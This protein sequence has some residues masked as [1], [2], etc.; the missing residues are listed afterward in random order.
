[1]TVRIYDPTLEPKGKHIDY[2]PR[3]KS[4]AGIRIGLVDNGKANAN[5]ILVGIAEIL[6]S[7]YGATAHVIRRKISHGI[8]ASREILDEFTSNCDVMIAGVGDCGSCSSGTVL[9]SVLFEQQGIPSASIVTDLFAPTGRAMMNSWGL[10]DF[11]FLTTKHPV[12]NLNTQ[13][14]EE[15]VREIVP[16]VVELLLKGQA[17]H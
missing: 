9:D 3:P 12:S 14:V 13:E 7:E 11:K 15:R 5:F 1:M 17:T 10:K 4:L 16:Q 2:A 6:E 8:P